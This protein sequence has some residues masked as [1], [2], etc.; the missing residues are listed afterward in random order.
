MFGQQKSRQTDTRYFLHPQDVQMSD[1]PSDSISCLEFA[2]V[3]SQ[4]SQGLEV[5][6][7]G[8]WDNQVR[9]GLYSGKP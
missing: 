8:S 2:P 6:A 7:C 5:L 3:I 1:A 4:P 9:V